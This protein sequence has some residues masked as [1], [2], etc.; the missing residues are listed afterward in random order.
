[1]AELIKLQFRAKILRIIEDGFKALEND[2]LITFTDKKSMHLFRKGDEVLITIENVDEDGKEE[3]NDGYSVIYCILK[4]HLS[5]G[6]QFVEAGFE[7]KSFF[8]DFRGIIT[9]KSMEKTDYWE[10]NSLL[11]IAIVRTTI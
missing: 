11:R 2:Y 3:I 4:N 10:R 5:N 6:F 1:M 7:P 8:W 9:Q